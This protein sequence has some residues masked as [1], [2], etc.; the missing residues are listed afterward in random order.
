MNNR[1]KHI[2]QLLQNEEINVMGREY[3]KA[4]QDITIPTLELQYKEEKR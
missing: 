2:V 1:S 3:E 4:M